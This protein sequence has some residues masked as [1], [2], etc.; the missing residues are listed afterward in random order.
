MS[1]LAERL[2]GMIGPAEHSPAARDAWSDVEGQPLR[3]ADIAE[4]LEGEWRGS[5][6]HSFLVVDRVYRPGYR[7]GR[8]SVA[9]I[10]PSADGWSKL[11]LLTGLGG[12][13]T[14]SILFLDVETTGLAGGAGTYAFLIGCGWFED[15]TFRVRQL[16]LSSYAA[17]RLMLDAVAEIARGAG[18]L[19]T[20]N[21]KSFDV[22]LIETRFVLHRLEPPFAATA[23]LDMLHPARRLWSQD[24]DAPG[25][26]CRLGMLEERLLGHL[27]EDDVSGFEIPSRYFHY[28]RSG[29]ARPLCAVFEHNR[30]DILALAMIA[31]RAAQLLEDGPVAAKS[32]REAVGLGRIYE[33]GGL[34]S[35]ARACYARAAE[36]PADTLTHAE[37]LRCGA[38]LARR[39][40]RYHDAAAGWR[41]LLHLPRCP[42]H[43]AR[44]ATEALAVHHEH[45]A[46]DLEAARRFAMQTL[47]FNI[48]R[49]RTEAVQ[50]RL[51]RLDRKLER[52]AEAALF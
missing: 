2:R 3:R 48:T 7:H 37:A 5:N 44:E 43:L 23:H 34:I 49:S 26:T 13:K 25:N 9:D 51:A 38:V 22:P 1:T 20:Y 29:D 46:R 50:H 8:V 31:A 4:L 11:D 6:G 41:A 36:M 14:R 16:F 27:R 33:R 47:Q 12:L 15:A 35:N 32:A 39:E 30:L 24:G 18:V 52:A 10:L 42:A 19:A 28:V 17:E 40:R 45:R 21:G